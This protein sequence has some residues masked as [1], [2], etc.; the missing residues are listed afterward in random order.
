MAYIT[1][2]ETPTKLSIFRPNLFFSFADG[3]GAFADDKDQD[4]TAK[5]LN[6]CRPLSP[7]K[8]IKQ[9]SECVS[10]GCTFSC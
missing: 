7:V 9:K 5:K 10:I 1:C 8:S 3:K 4:Q 6:L 2:H